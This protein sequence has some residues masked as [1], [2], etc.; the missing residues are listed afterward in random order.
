[1]SP[2]LRILVDAKPSP[3]LLLRLLTNSNIQITRTFS[4]SCT[5][6]EVVAL[7]SSCICEIHLEFLA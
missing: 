2:E 6:F 1:M 7:L 4:I 5:V 3:G